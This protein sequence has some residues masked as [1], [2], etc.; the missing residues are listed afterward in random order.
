MLERIDFFATAPAMRGFQGSTLPVFRVVVTGMELD[1]CSMRLVIEPRYKPGTA[2]LTKSCS[3]FTAGQ[4]EGYSV[5]LTST[6]TANLLGVYNGYF[7]LTDGDGKDYKNL[8]VPLEILPF[9]KEVTS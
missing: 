1:G 8:C 3:Y 2:A 4:E 5:L 6:D 9:P 7:I